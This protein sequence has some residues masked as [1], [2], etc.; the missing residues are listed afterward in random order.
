MS[1]DS[2]SNRFFARFPAAAPA[3]YGVLIVGFAAVIWISLADLIAQ[4]SALATSVDLLDRLEARRGNPDAANASPDAVPTGSPF[5]GGET[6]TVA[7]A[8]LL[9]RVAGAITRFG[10]SVQS[11][12]VDLQGSQAKSDFVTLLVSC[13]IDEANLQKLL[14]DIEAGMPY[15]FVDQLT[16]RAPQATATANGS[17]M[18]LLLAVSGRWSGKK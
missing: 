1:N 18:S 2:A 4:R 9:Q 13:E 11:S 3:L 8:E 14:Y 12:Q 17:R 15:L 6:I 7:G 10:G 5:L 16:A